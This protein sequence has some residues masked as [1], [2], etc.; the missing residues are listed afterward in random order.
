MQYAIVILAIFLNL[1]V[2]EGAH[3]FAMMRLGVPLKEA[4]LGIPVRFLPH[5]G[6][7][8]KSGVRFTIHPLLIGAYV[9]PTPDGERAINELPYHKKAFIFGAGVL[10]NVALG[11]LFA[12]LWLAVSGA[13]VD[14][15]FYAIITAVILR[16]AR[17]L[18]AYGVP[19]L[20][21]LMV[22][23]I[24]ISLLGPSSG[25]S[26][27][28]GP[29]GIGEMTTRM[30]TLKETISLAIGLSFGIGL[31]NALPCIPLD[32]GRI[33]DA[34]LEKFRVPPSLRAAYSFLSLFVFLSLIV[35]IWA[36]DISRL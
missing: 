4:G 17:V 3:A 25:N 36:N 34:V 29:I 33:A 15:V 28:A 31:I 9:M 24:A 32:G 26:G 22:A 18:T 7:T 19:V 5:A 12:A 2:H 30:S 13:Y 6:F 10:S 14:A 27:L 23:F 1:I 21:V 20:A 11:C 35:L 16:F 8:T